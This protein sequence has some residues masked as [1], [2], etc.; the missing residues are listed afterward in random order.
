M[1]FVSVK[2]RRYRQGRNGES[3]R[4]RLPQEKHT[5]SISND[6]LEIIH[7]RTLGIE[8]VVFCI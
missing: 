2:K 5:N 3:G 6:E 7:A 8:Q 1:G 4:N